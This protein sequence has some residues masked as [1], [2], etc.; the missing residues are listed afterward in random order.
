MSRKQ[1]LDYLE[2]FYKHLSNDIVVVYGNHFSDIHGLLIDFLKDKEGFFYQAKSCDINLQMRLL[3]SDLHD[4]DKKGTHISNDF[5]K[6]V[7]SF[8]SSSDS[9]KVI[10]INSFEYILKENDTFINLLST[11]KAFPSVKGKVMFVLASFDIHWIE[12]VMVSFLGKSSYEINGLVKINPYSISELRQL[13]RNMPESDFLALYSVIGGN[14][15]FWYH[16]EN[17]SSAKDFICKHILRR[18]SYIFQSGLKILPND[19]RQ[20]SVYNTLLYYLAIGDNK[21]ND[22][23]NKTGYE[24][25]KISIYLNNL[26]ER[27]LIYKQQPLPIGGDNCTK[28]GVYMISEPFVVF[29]Y[30][31]IFPHISSIDTYTPERF[32][33]KYIDQAFNAFI[34]QFYPKACMDMLLSMSEKGMIPFEIKDVIPF[35]DK[36]GAIDFIGLGKDNY[37]VCG[38]RYASPHMAFVKLEAIKKTCQKAGFKPSAIYLFSASGFDQKLNMYCHVND[39]VILFETNEFRISGH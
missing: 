37:I 39:D 38:C 34:E 11:I 6:S 12:N 22:L 25:A 18:N 26:L 15:K 13:Y 8:I 36:T 32:F 17:E 9:K 1:D 4:I 7:E 3:V 28:K 14:P 29:W 2:N 10:V 27:G 5:I 20:P 35:A 23:Y 16:A 30:R 21:L 19:L 33:R 31:F 24:R